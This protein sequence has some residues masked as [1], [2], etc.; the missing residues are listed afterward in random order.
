MDYVY[1]D[2]LKPD[3]GTYHDPGVMPDF[4]VGTIPSQKNPGI[5]TESSSN[6]NPINQQLVIDGKRYRI[7]VQPNGT[8]QLIPIR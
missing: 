2:E 3:T 5:T 6:Y 1:T 4:Y 8:V 7:N